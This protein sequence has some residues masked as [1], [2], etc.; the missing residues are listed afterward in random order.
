M[1]SFPGVMEIK[2]LIENAKG[3]SLSLENPGSP[4][5]VSGITF[6][7][8]RV[9]P[10]NIYVCLHWEEFLESHILTDG[11]AYIREALANGAAIILVEKGV[12]LEAG[13]S[14][15]LIVAD[16]A[17]K[18]MAV[19]ANEFY[20]RPLDKM[21][22]IGV[23]GTN[24][25]T[26]INFILQSIFS[27]AGRRPGIVGTM[28]I[29]SDYFNVPPGLYTSPLSSDLFHSASEML[30]KGIDTVIM[31][32]TS[33]GISLFREYGTD[34]DA[35]IFT[36]FSQDHLDF[37][38]SIHEYKDIKLELFRRLDKQPSKKNPVAIINVD[39]P[40]SGEFLE[41]A[42][43]SIVTYGL[44]NP[45]D[46]SAK[47]I[48]I[49]ASGSRF[50]VLYEEDK[51]LPVNFSL[52]GEFNIYNALASF[53]AARSQGL[54]VGKI[55]IGLESIQNIPGRF[56]TVETG[57]DF[58]VLV[59]Y[60]HTPDSLEK[61]LNSA[62]NLKP[63]RLIL[64]FGCGG[65]RDSKKRPIMGRLAVDISDYV[66][67]T[68]DNPRTEDPRKIVDDILQGIPEEKKG[69]VEAIVD[70]RQAIHAALSLAASGDLVVLAG[71]GHEDYQIIGK[72]KIHFDDK[73]EVR[74]YLGMK[75]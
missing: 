7:Y 51:T 1:L 26:T 21:K 4:L 28:G 36:N 13:I 72:E 33:H 55:K 35:A 73:E 66:V 38:D 62:R 39:D 75:D 58:A 23:T 44:K 5:D 16:N 49:S 25:K 15:P 31:E 8:K 65:D 48:S 6:D 54:E 20:Q 22:V 40:C 3:V 27:A 11:Y 69:A 42:N 43:T 57:K 59:D 37:H 24:G 67:V 46:V 2:K 34:Y 17:N 30:S 53:A 60:A 47:D 10:G 70:R 63:N 52:N 45:A 68:S 64:V 9:K 29:R 14:C 19:L 41:A 50:T 32:S 71:K 56:E 12:P 74:N 18:A 61:I